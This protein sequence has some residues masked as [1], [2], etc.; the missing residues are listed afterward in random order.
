MKQMGLFYLFQTQINLILVDD[1]QMRVKVFLKHIDTIEVIKN[2]PR[3]SDEEVKK[4][5]GENIKVNE[6]KG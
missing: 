6:I 1:S 4:I 3:Y 5:I 2:S